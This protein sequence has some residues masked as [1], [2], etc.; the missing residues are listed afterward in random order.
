MKHPFF[1]LILL[2]S[3]LNSFSQCYPVFRIMDK[4]PQFF[5]SE[6]IERNFPYFYRYSAFYGKNTDSFTSVYGYY[7][8]SNWQRIGPHSMNGHAMKLMMWGNRILGYGRIT[9][10]GSLNAPPQKYFGIMEY[11][12]GIWDTIPGCTFDSAFAFEAGANA[13]SLFFLTRSNNNPYQGSVY[14]YD[15]SQLKFVQILN[16]E[17]GNYLKTSLKSGTNRMLLSNVK[18]ID[19]V[20]CKGFAYYEN[21]SVKLSNAA[22]FDEFQDYAIDK[23]TD[24]I[25]AMNLR[26]NPVVHHFGTTAMPSRNTLLTIGTAFNPLHVYNGQLIWMSYDGSSS[27][28][29][30]NILCAGDSVWKQIFNNMQISGI[31]MTNPYC[32]VNG[33]YCYMTVNGVS[34]ALKLENG[35]LLEGIAFIDKDSSCQPDSGEH[36]LKN[37]MVI[38]KSPRFYS[39]SLTDDSGRYAMFVV[40]DT[41]EV[42]GGGKLNVCAG[43]NTVI[44][45]GSN[46]YVKDVP[47]QDPG[48]F[49]VKISI[50]S[51]QRSRWNSTDMFGAVIEN[52]GYPLDSVDIEFL[53]DSKLNVKNA[54]N[55]FYLTNANQ[56]VGRLYNLDYY[57]KRWVYLSAWIDTASTKPDSVLC[58]KAIASIDTLEFD[59]LNNRDSACGLVVYSYDPNYKACD[60]NMIDPGIS[61]KLEY[62]IEFQNEGN[63]D[64]YDVNVTDVLSPKLD[65]KSLQIHSASHPYTMEFS[66]GRLKF[67]FRDI[68]LKPKKVDEAGSKGYISFSINTV[69]G[70]EKGD[71]ILNKAYIYFD[72]NAPVIT[73][74]TVVRIDQTGTVDPLLPSLAAGIKVYPN[75]AG[76]LVK[77]ECKLY[78]PVHL[79][80]AM[81]KLIGSIYPENGIAEFDLSA[82]PSGIYFIRCG[83]YSSKFIKQD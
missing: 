34:K 73:N 75:P 52:N 51:P 18:K 20:T 23:A 43:S 67:T 42:Y 33:T 4:Q 9:R 82:L 59:Y 68:F 48:G 30:Y 54:D 39:S 11:K 41:I 31:S 62:Y 81:G 35:S 63:D 53:L 6:S 47:V 17:S 46:T 12:S 66:E 38:G 77:V 8:G 15:T 76:N 19:G 70:L 22:G 71:S 69:N 28:R 74:T 61:T 57:E 65:F 50:I 26:S 5:I 83:E 64:A 32:A 13:G 24:H 14:K 60:R 7:D 79:Y 37:Y 27:N 25:Y 80:N 56:A 45:S 3:S 36:R 44:I 72:L 29:A 49:D 55:N 40:S 21:D 1:L 58:H 2:F 78:A 16:Y 10:A